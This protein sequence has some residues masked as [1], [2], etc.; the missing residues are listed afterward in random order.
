MRKT[1]R[2]TE[3]QL[4][5]VIEKI[6]NEGDG[7][8][9]ELLDDFLKKETSKRGPKI[10]YELRKQ[11][12]LEHDKIFKEVISKVEEGE[13][14]KNALKKLGIDDTRFFYKMLSPE[15]YVILKRIKASS[16]SHTRHEFKELEKSLKTKSP[17]DEYDWKEKEK[18]YDDYSDLDEKCWKG[19]TQK[20]MKTMFGKK[21]PNCVKINK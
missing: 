14:I 18:R 19:Y 4:I 11:K 1:I 21:Y 17:W 13:T 3:S 15:Q 9:S 20:G 7:E 16:H 5:K 8:T 2:L 10:N 6:I 12:K